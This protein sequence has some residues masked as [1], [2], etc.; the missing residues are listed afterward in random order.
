M[1]PRINHGQP[2][3]LGA[4]RQERCLQGFEVP[5]AECLCLRTHYRVDG[6]PMLTPNYHR[7]APIYGYALGEAVFHRLQPGLG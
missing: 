1:E 4:W 5:E 6:I 3:W 7:G 2:G